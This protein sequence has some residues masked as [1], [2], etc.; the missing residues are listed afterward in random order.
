MIIFEVFT[1]CSSKWKTN[2][3]GYSQGTIAEINTRLS[4]L[5][6]V[7][8]LRHAEYDSLPKTCSEKQTGR[9]TDSQIERETKKADRQSNRQ[10]E[11]QIDRQAER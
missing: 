7:H 2:T 11:R 5:G 10:A 4:H 9:Q 1:D 6:T 8:I 3:A